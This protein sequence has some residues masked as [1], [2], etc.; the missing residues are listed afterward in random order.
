MRKAVYMLVAVLLAMFLIV[1]VRRIKHEKHE[2]FEDATN[3][4]PT[5]AIRGPDGRIHV[6][7][8]NR[9]FQTL[10]DYIGFL[11][12]LYAKGSACIP[13]KVKPHRSTIDGILGGLGNGKQTPE[14]VNLEGTSRDIMDHEGEEGPF[15]KKPIN[16]LDDYE[17]SRVFEQERGARNSLSQASKNELL[18]TRVLDW[19][20]LPFNSEERAKEEDSFIAG[21]MEGG[22]REPK[23]GVF[24]NT[25]QGKT[26]EPP[27]VEAA[28]MREQ[29]ILA[30][31]RPTDISKHIMDNETEAV[32]NLVNKVYA[33]DKAWEPVLTKVGDNQW[34]VNELRPKPRKERYESETTQ[35]LSMMEAKGLV[36]PPPIVDIDDRIRGDPYFDKSGLGDRDNNR[37]WNYKDF[38]KWTPGLE[39]VFAPTADNKAW[40]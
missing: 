40:Y 21:R 9:S 5:E 16:K 39:R 1:G 13:P 25:V 38:N 37:L 12:G 11:S 26:L 22:F 10:S 30:A 34:E 2:K 15:V 36:V 28:R 20:N 27:D 17:Y 24:F 23:S 4:C 7:P 31:Y 6:N 19:A 33:E 32:A 29:K 18:E 3:D 14:S 8:G 35:E